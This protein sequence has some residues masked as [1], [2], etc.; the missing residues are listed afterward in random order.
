[1]SP[2]NAGSVYSKPI[3]YNETLRVPSSTSRTLYSGISD[4]S[5][6]HIFQLS[7]GLERAKKTSGFSPLLKEIGI[8]AFPVSVTVS[9]AV[10]SS[11][12]YSRVTGAF[13]AF[14]VVTS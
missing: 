13:I 2:L 11:S 10:L 12:Q 14:L 1:M 9:R 8:D 3:M 5:L 6:V 7:P 4:P